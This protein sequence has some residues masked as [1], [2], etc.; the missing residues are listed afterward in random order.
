MSATS[1]RT[2]VWRLLATSGAILPVTLWSTSVA[3]Q[4]TEPA[5]ADAAAAPA[6]GVQDIIVTAQRRSQNLQ[7]VPAAVTALTPAILT[8]RNIA[9]TQDLMQVTPGLQVSTLTSGGSSGAATFFL[10]G[11]GQQRAANGSEPAVG[12]YVDDIYYPTLQ[13]AN[14]DVVDLDGV[15]VLR[16]PQGT[17]FGRNTIGGAIRYTTAQPGK[18]FSGS[19]SGTYGSYQRRDISGY[20][21][22]PLGD[23]AAL[24]L[25]AGHLQRD[26]F[27][28]RQSGGPDA[29][30]SKTDLVRGALRLDPASNFRI[31]ATAQ[32]QESKLDGFSYV[33]RGPIVFPPSSLL[34]PY[35]LTAAGILNPLDN[36]YAAQCDFCQAGSNA[37]ESNKNSAFNASLVMSWGVAHGI[38]LK[39]LSGFTSVVANAIIDYDGTPLN[40]YQAYQSNRTRAFSQE[41]QLNANLFDD[42]LSFVGGAFYF[43]DEFKYNFG[44]PYEGFGTFFNPVRFSANG[45]SPATPQ[46]RRTHSYAGYADATFAITDKLTFILGGRYSKDHKFAYANVN[47]TGVISTNDA[48]FNSTTG[49]IGLKYQATPNAM[50]YATVSTGFR[51]GGFNY[52]ASIRRF[53]AFQPENS[54][55]YEIGGRVDLFDRHLRFNPTFFYNKWNNIQVQSVVPDAVTGINIVSLNNAA[56]AHTYGFELETTAAINRNFEVYGNLATLEAHYDSIGTATGITVNTEFQRAPKLTYAVGATARHDVSGY[57]VLA[58]LNWGWQDGQYSTPTLSDRLFLPSYGL[59]S[60]RLQVS[61]PSKRYTLAVFATNLTNAAYYVGGVGY[62]ANVG[63]NR[64][65]IGR[66]RE[67]GVNLKV[68]F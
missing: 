30:A 19:I 2:Q 24:R 52:V 59:L 13:G 1:R 33:T 61:D 46:R 41:L 62:S 56:K 11:M 35:N 42:R 4:A 47:N 64:Y 49:R 3:A 50:V 14:F 57:G 67:F 48:V 38:T 36:R 45:T 68:G 51:A 37:G 60:A 17:L 18:E 20:V 23:V 65:D 26:G 10:R 8:E 39:S 63:L 53:V 58:N 27:V 6:V 43:Q 34:A 25:T 5:Q 66:P 54:R 55:S 15:E 21:N 40:L 9:T 7:A 28:R 32:Y 22:I 29:A 44:I 12:I 31:D 16:G